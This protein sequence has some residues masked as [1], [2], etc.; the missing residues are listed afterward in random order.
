MNKTQYYAIRG[1]LSLESIRCELELED[2]RKRG[3]IGAAMRIFKDRYTK[4][5]KA[6]EILDEVMNNG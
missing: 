2:A 6:I 5:N 4:A 3:F 1:V